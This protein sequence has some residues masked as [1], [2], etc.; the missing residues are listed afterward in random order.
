[1]QQDAKPENK[2]D[3]FCFIVFYSALNSETILNGKKEYLAGGW[4]KPE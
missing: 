2:V 1:V 3:K 4:I